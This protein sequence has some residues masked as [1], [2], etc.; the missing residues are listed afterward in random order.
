MHIL[1][2]QNILSPSKALGTKKNDEL[3]KVGG[4]VLFPP[5]S[6]AKAYQ[7]DFNLQID[8]IM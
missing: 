8:L 3:Q 6:A 4:V 5:W 7:L 2:L 1:Y